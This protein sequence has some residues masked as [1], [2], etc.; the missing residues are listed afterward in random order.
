MLAP[1]QSS[2]VF[3]PSVSIIFPESFL[4]A[5]LDIVDA[6]FQWLR[7]RLCVGTFVQMMDHRGALPCVPLHPLV[8]IRLRT[9]VGLLQIITR[10]TCTFYYLTGGL[11]FSVAGEEIGRLYPWQCSGTI[12]AVSLVRCRYRYPKHSYFLDGW[13]PVP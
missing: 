8:R 6:C 12:V 3:Y 1:C 4:S 10:A 13:H 11:S 7:C 2:V 9:I 5:Y